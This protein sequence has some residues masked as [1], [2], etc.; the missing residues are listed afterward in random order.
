MK[1]TTWKC[2]HCGAIKRGQKPEGWIAVRIELA[3]L[4]EM[5]LFPRGARSHACSL[6]CALRLVADPQLHQIAVER[7]ETE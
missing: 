2:D 3:A 5:T 1:T 6:D 4:D 7:M